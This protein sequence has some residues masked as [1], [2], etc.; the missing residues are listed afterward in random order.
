MPGG[1]RTR[2]PCRASWPPPGLP[3]PLMQCRGCGCCFSAS[4]SGSA[5]RFLL[6]S[7][8]VGFLQP[9][10][11]EQYQLPQSPSPCSP[12]QMQ[13]Q[14]SGTRRRAS[15]SA[16]WIGFGVGRGGQ[17]LPVHS[18]I[19]RT[20]LP[21]RQ[22]DSAPGRPALTVPIVQQAGRAGA[23]LG[24]AVGCRLPLLAAAQL[25]G[26]GLSCGAVGSNH[27]S[28]ANWENRESFS[29]DPPNP[30]R[31]RQ[32]WWRRAHGAGKGASVAVAAASSTASS[33]GVQSWGRTAA[34]L[35]PQGCPLQAPAWL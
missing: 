27:R 12:S 29:C 20:A 35:S 28:D 23:A 25:W 34:I 26:R 3:A 17:G 19:Y 14:Y 31:S 7:P 32:E 15:G 10:G 33:R 9:P 6:H 1:S 30:P 18:P 16:V 24:A 8:S 5:K 4:S 21:E 22:S 2:P 11:S 13:Q